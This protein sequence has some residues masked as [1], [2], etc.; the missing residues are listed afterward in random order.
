MKEVSEK[1]REPRAPPNAKKNKRNYKI[2]RK[3]KKIDLP[4]YRG[5]PFP[6]CWL[7]PCFV[8][9]FSQHPRTLFIFTLCEGV[10]LFSPS[11]PRFSHRFSPLFPRHGTAFFRSETRKEVCELLFH[12]ARYS[13]SLLLD[14]RDNR[15]LPLGA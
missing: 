1:M 10:C 6:G 3:T 5:V 7:L 2:K 15:S 13:L 4:A 8:L 12:R 11:P 9:T 14:G